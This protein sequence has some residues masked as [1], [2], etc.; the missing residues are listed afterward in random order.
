MDRMQYEMLVRRAFN[1][2]RGGVYGAEAGIFD[3][4]VREIAIPMHG[5][6]PQPNFEM[7]LAMGAVISWMKAAFQKIHDDNMDND[8]IRETMNE[9]MEILSVPSME[10]VDKAGDKACELLNIR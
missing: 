10:S 9:C 5:E 4:L 1:C 7:G 2:G 6:A 8:Q 3:N